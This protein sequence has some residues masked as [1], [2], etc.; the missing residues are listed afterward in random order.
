M[1]PSCERAIVARRLL[2]AR[3]PA[4][5]AEL[6]IVCYGRGRARGASRRTRA[7]ARGHPRRRAAGGHLGRPAARG[8]AGRRPRARRRRRVG[9]SHVETL[10]APLAPGAALVTVLDRARCDHG[11]DAAPPA[12]R[13]ADRSRSGRAHGVVDPGVK[14]SQVQEFARHTTA[15]YPGDHGE[16]YAGC[17]PEPSRVA[18]TVENLPVRWRTGEETPIPDQAKD[19]AQA[20]TVRRALSRL[21]ARDGRPLSRQRDAAARA[22]SSAPAAT[23]RCWPAA[24][25]ANTACPRACGSA[26]PPTLA[27]GFPRGPLGLRVLARRRMAFA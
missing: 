17:G 11:A 27:P 5:G 21:L 20:R 12:R 23:T 7:I 22:L 14:V 13:H 15:S 9:R 19:D 25:S 10:L 18:A 6:A 1:T 2:A 3:R 4:P 16:L 24:C 8:L 26:S